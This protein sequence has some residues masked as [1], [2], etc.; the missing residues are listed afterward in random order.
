MESGGRDPGGEREASSKSQS[1][2]IGN[3]GTVK[4]TDFGL[5][6][7]ALV[8]ADLTLEGQ[9]IG[10]PKYLSPEQASGAAVDARSDIYSLG[11]TMYEMVSGRPPFDG[12][13]PMEIP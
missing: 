2:V 10:T 4:V 5:A 12:T 6:K 13:T 9:T 3:D 7:Q 8:D 11:V 1:L